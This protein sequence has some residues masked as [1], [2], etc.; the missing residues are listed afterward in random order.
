ME[1]VGDCFGWVAGKGPEGISG[2]C[3]MQTPPST[4]QKHKTGSVAIPW[5]TGRARKNILKCDAY[6]EWVGKSNDTLLTPPESPL[7]HEVAFDWSFHEIIHDAAMSESNDMFFGEEMAAFDLPQT[8]AM[9]ATVTA[10]AGHSLG[11]LGSLGQRDLRCYEVL[12]I[13]D[14]DDDK[15]DGS[16]EVAP[17]V[18]P[19]LPALICHEILE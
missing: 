15:P 10:T 19:H 12:E 1:E 6:L 11:S 17:A 3:G 9:M 4:P 18:D 8:N 2:L 16:C 7:E 14:D 5:Q 13:D